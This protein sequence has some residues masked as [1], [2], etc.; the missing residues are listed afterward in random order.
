MAKKHKGNGTG[1]ESQGA[2]KR[3]GVETGNGHTAST[4]RGTPKG[5]VF[6]TADG[7]VTGTPAGKHS[8][9]R[10]IADIITG[11]HSR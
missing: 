8:R 1:S 9:L 6:R 2:G 5:V 7:R 10:T 11:K 4:G 3:R